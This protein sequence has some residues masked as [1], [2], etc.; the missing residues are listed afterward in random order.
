MANGR[1]DARVELH[2]GGRRLAFDRSLRFRTA[3]R[4]IQITISPELC[5]KTSFRAARTILDSN[6]QSPRLRNFFEVDFI[7]TERGK[8]GIFF[9][10]NESSRENRVKCIQLLQ[11]LLLCECTVHNYLYV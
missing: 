10:V 2:F 5:N 6:L 9:F 8:R 11:S 1:F 3:S 7:I 4:K